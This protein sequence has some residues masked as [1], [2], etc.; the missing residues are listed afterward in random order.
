M[1]KALECVLKSGD[2]VK[3]TIATEVYTGKAEILQ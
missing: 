3:L 1:A 2:T